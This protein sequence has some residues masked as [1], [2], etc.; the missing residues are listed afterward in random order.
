MRV[1]AWCTLLAGAAFLPPAFAEEPYVPL[2]QR[3]TPEQLRETGL[4]GL[5]AAQ[6]ERLNAILRADTAAVV[7]REQAR[8]RP[9]GGG[10]FGP[11]REPVTT[12]L[13]GE[14]RGWSNGTRFTLENG[15]TWRVI[16][17]PE[18]YVSKSKF[19]ASPA[20]LLSPGLLGG[21]YLQVDGDSMRA[22]VTQVN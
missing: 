7:A 17:T 20:I 18:Y 11:A 22:K 5:S 12:R 9:D 3:L 15:Q 19:K 14:F 16:D 10:L 1:L 2:E 21:W 8:P 6:L 13:V 4:D